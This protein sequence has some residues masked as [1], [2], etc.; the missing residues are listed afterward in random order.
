MCFLFLQAHAA[1]GANVLRVFAHNDFSPDGMQPSLGVYNEDAIKRLDLVLVA[2]AQQGIRLILVLT[3]YWPFVGGMQK[4]VDNGIGPGNDLEL[5]YTDP[6][7]RDYYKK[8][9]RHI[10]TRTNTYTGQRYIGK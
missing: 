8:W 7:L 9:V 2:A 6:V 3:N 10:V 5:F 4:W 1:R